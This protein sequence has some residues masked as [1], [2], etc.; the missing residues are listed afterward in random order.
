MVE[1][2]GV[3]DCE[4]VPYALSAPRPARWPLCRKACA[5]KLTLDSKEP[6]ED[7]LRV[8]G[9]LYG[10]TLVVAKEDGR[11]QAVEPPAPV[12]KIHAIQAIEPVEPVEPTENLRP[13][14]A[15]RRGRAAAS[16]RSRSGPATSEADGEKP[17]QTAGPP[18]FQSPS[19]TELRSW[20]RA[21][22]LTVSDRGRV[23]TSVRSA[24]RSAH[25]A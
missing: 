17:K 15:G 12:E 2:S 22:G 9:A 18:S 24:Y 16:M 13:R 5:L 20:A 11:G 6:I 8:V 23:P 25:G 10:V 14:K 21:N 4:L 7:T 19:N 3:F 1:S